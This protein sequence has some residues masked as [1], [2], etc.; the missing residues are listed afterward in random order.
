ME[1]GS[2]DHLDEAGHDR[3]GE[4]GESESDDDDDLLPQYDDL[5]FANNSKAMPADGGGESHQKNI[6]QGKDVA[7][8][9]QDMQNMESDEDADESR[10]DGSPRASNHCNGVGGGEAFAEQTVSGGAAENPP[11]FRIR[12]GFSGQEDDSSTFTVQNKI[13]ISGLKILPIDLNFGH[14]F[15]LN[16]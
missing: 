15:I 2:A 1:R 9:I 6:F 3:H 12:R 5:R 8:L 7:Q 10:H 14:F 13:H 16:F 4:H 11:N